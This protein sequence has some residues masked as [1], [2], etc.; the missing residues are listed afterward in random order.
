MTRDHEVQE[1]LTKKNTDRG[2]RGGQRRGHLKSK[3]LAL[4]AESSSNKEKGNSPS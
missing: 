4:K 2:G 3:L 1:D